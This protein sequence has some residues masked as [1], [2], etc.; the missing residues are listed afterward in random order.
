M[1][2][3]NLNLDLIIYCL[4]RYNIYMLKKVLKLAEELGLGVVVIDLPEN[5]E[6]AWNSVEEL[7]ELAPGYQKDW[8][9]ILHEVCHALQY[10]NETPLW[11]NYCEDYNSYCAELE[12]DA[13]LRGVGWLY[14]NG[15]H[16]KIEEF[17]GRAND[18]LYHYGLEIE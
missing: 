18:N 15:Y 3:Q 1:I 9:V 10:L 4:M 7:V 8:R 2:A 13:E 14:I 17:V 6:G 11:L 16:D 5:F 12:L